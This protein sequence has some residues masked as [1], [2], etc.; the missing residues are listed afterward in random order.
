MFLLVERNMMHRNVRIFTRRELFDLVWSKPMQKVAEELGISDRGL[1]KICIRHSLPSPSRGYWAR[2][3]AGQNLKPP[4]YR[5]VSNPSLD[6]IEVT[7]T[8]FNLPEETGE[9]TRKAEANRVERGQINS[10]GL[11]PPPPVEKPHRVAAPTAGQLRKARPNQY[12]GVSAT[13]VGT[14]GVIVHVDR[15]ER[16]IAFLHALATALEAAG[17]QLQ[18]DGARMKI[19]VGPDEV[20]FTLIERTR[21]ERHIPTEDEKGLHERQQAKRQRAA[22][23][24]NWD[25]YRSLP[26][27]QPWPEYDTVYTGQLAFQIESW[28]QGFRKCPSQNFSSH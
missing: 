7:A 26:Y 23:R 19:A 5:E 21:R 15:V 25:L 10:S 8:V 9:I 27:Q 16:V 12:G 11:V 22:D 4:P 18:P 14:C 6:R 3:T 13:G 1:A 24:Q 17:L 2:V 20:A 28:A